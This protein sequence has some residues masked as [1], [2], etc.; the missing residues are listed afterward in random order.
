MLASGSDSA[1]L[2]APSTAATATTP[3]RSR[4]S[5]A[6]NAVPGP[7]QSQTLFSSSI[8][9]SAMQHANASALDEPR[10]FIPNIIELLNPNEDLALIRETDDVARKTEDHWR[11]GE[12]E[13]QD[14]LRALTRQLHIAKEA[15]EAPQREHDSTQHSEQL[16]QLKGLKAEL[17][18]LN[19]EEREE[20]ELQPDEISLKLQ[21]F[22]SLGIKLLMDKDGTFSKCQIPVH[23][24]NDIHNVDF[25]EPHTRF[26]YANVLWDMA[27]PPMPP[28]LL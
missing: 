27:T 23:S 7:S 13:A 9:S 8:S 4:I 24:Q 18:A 19:R 21:V 22:R 14:L 11:K 25:K 20:S 10:A 1:S 2:T 5:N 17:A 15:A 16:E 3:S 6:Y 26:Y 28:H 12:L